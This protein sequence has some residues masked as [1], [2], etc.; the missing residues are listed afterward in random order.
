MLRLIAAMSVLIAAATP[1][2]LAQNVERSG[3]YSMSPAEGGGFARLDTETGAM[4]I[5]QRQAEAWTCRDM[6]DEG[7]KI[8]LENEVLAR[9][10]KELKA[11]LQKLE[12]FVVAQGGKSGD[13]GDRPGQQF[14]LP[15]EQDVDQ[16][17]DYMGRMFK[18]FRDKLKELEGDKSATPL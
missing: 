18:K 4:S 5:C 2:A 9:Q 17:L 7:L 10:N 11:E 13:K 1:S 12:D 15:S 14:K 8:R 3:R 6:D 16:A